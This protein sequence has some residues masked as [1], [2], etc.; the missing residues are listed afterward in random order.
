M[1]VYNLKMIHDEGISH[2]QKMSWIHKAFSNL[3]NGFSVEEGNNKEM[4]SNKNSNLITLFKGHY[5]SSH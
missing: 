4:N 3:L 1:N 2:A 5:W